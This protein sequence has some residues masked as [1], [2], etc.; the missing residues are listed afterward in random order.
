M[1]VALTKWDYRIQSNLPPEIVLVKDETP[2]TFNVTVEASNIL[3]PRYAGI[4]DVITFRVRYL[5][6]NFRE[7]MSLSA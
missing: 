7:I 3:E 1:S 2:P 4:D 6:P 5:P